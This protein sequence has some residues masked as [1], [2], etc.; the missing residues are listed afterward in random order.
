M[1]HAIPRAE[2]SE[3]ETYRARLFYW[4]YLVQHWL[5]PG[6]GVLT[7]PDEMDADRWIGPTPES[8]HENGWLLEPEHVIEH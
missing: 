7:Q 8:L 6:P 2:W 1:A 3:V 4:H 5:V